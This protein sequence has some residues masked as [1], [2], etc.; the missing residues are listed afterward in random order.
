MD[1]RKIGSR[2][3]N[4]VDTCHHFFFARPVS[5]VKQAVF[6]VSQ[7]VPSAKS[8][9]PPLD[10]V[11]RELRAG[12]G[13][14]QIAITNHEFPIVNLPGIRGG[15]PRPSARKI[16]ESKSPAVA[17]LPDNG[18]PFLGGGSVSI[19]W[20]GDRRWRRHGIGGSVASRR[21]WVWSRAP[22]AAI[23]SGRR[24]GRADR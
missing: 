8:Y 22:G 1:K 12:N 16:R 17:I 7:L 15:S 6:G 2:S 4:S 11:V 13:L 21:C 19:S 20:R 5:P 14:R 18:G 23:T 10:R 3:G 24:W 9:H